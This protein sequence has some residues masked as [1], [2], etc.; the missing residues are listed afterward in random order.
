MLVRLLVEFDLGLASWTALTLVASLVG[1]A[2][3]Q[4]L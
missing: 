4:A 2:M 3:L 1:E